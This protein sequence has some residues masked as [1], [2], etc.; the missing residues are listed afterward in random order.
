MPV[1]LPTPRAVRT[2]CVDLDA[3]T[4]PWVA[5]GLALIHTLIVGITVAGGVAIFT[6]RFRQFRR[7]DFFAWAFLACCLGQLISLVLTGGCVLT[8]WQ[9]QLELQ[10]GEGGR[11][12]ATFLQRFL[13]W[14]PDWFALRGVPLLTLAALSGATIQIVGAVKRNRSGRDT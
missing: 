1:S 12:P 2:S 8:D 13:P 3:A 14:L 11:M 9:R 6:G 5:R 4:V 10:W 7:D